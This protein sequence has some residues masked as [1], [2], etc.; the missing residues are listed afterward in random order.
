M[1]SNF[2]FLTL[3]VTTQVQVNTVD[4]QNN[5][6]S[7]FNPTTSTVSI[8]RTGYYYLHINAGAQAHKAVGMRIVR[9]GS[10]VIA[11][12]VRGSTVHSGEDTL[13]RSAIVRLDKDDT[14]QVE[15][16][17]GSAVYSD[18]NRQTSFTG[19]FLFNKV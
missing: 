7:P 19:F 8:D 6:F 16:V 3:I 5:D 13:G 12:L 1:P 17:G 2:I 9:N 11:G 14:L 10:E 18:A 15:L 4:R